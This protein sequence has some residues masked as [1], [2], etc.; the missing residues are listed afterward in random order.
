MYKYA[1]VPGSEHAWHK[2]DALGIRI[3]RAWSES[4]IR[5]GESEAVMIRRGGECVAAV[6]T[7][8]G[9]VAMGNSARGTRVGGHDYFSTFS[10]EVKYRLMVILKVVRRNNGGFRFLINAGAL[11]L[12]SS[13]SGMTC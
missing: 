10:G 13:T 12:L 11:L 1:E 2:E 4:D 9:D 7:R 6:K 8:V 5:I 3:R